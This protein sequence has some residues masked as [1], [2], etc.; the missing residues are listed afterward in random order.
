M[1]ETSSAGANAA[2]EPAAPR[3]VRVPVTADATLWAQAHGAADARRTLIVLHGGPGLSHHYTRPLRALAGDDLQVI[4]FDQRGVGASS[5][6]GEAHHSLAHQVADLEVLREHFALEQVMLLGH[7]WGGLIAMTYAAEHPE[8]VSALVLVDS[9][10]PDSDTMSR[11]FDVF[12]DR[13]AERIAQGH[14]PADPPPVVDGDGSAN[15]EALLPVYFHD[16]RHDE[17]T[18]LGG[19][20]CDAA[21]LDATHR[22]SATFDC[23]EGL[24]RLRSPSVVF[25]G[26]SDPF[27]LE[28]VESAASA[29]ENSLRA[30]VV[31][32]RCGHIP[33]EECPGPFFTELRRFL[34]APWSYG[35]P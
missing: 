28:G 20:R 8:R 35:G 27:G 21:V 11:T 1:D 30:V 14:V 29:L 25:H 23:R 7:S 18:H 16:P 17:A 24:G 6:M 26:A 12:D 13:L 34:S 32:E 19:S 22:N 5:P 33:W 10:P 4:L 15:L 9:A 31:L 2:L 3:V